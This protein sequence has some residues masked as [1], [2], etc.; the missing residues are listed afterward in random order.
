MA[1]A[2]QDR[3]IRL[4]ST[5]GPPANPGQQQEQKG[6]VL[7]KEYMKVVPTVIVWDGIVS[8]EESQ[9]EREEDEPEDEVWDAMQAV[10]S[11]SEDEGKAAR[12]KEKKARSA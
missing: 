7:G 2:S 11:D 4:H 12:R 6:E 9:A 5:F 10:E 3:Y 1:S 8:A